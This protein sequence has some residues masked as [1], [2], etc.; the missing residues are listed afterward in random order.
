MKM[1]KKKV[2][3]IALA[4]ALIAILSFGTLAWFNST[5]TVTNIFNV[6]TSDEDPDEIFSVDIWEHVDKDGN[7]A[8][9]D[10]EKDQDGLTFDDIVPGG[11]YEKTPYVENTGKYDQWV[12][13]VVTVTDAEAWTNALGE[14]YELDKIFIGHPESNWERVFEPYKDGDTL[15]Y[16]YYYKNVLK[17]GDTAMLFKAVQLPGE[18]TQEDIAPLQGGFELTLRA[19]AIQA[20]AIGDYASGH[21]VPGVDTAQ[22]AFSYV[23]WNSYETYEQAMEEFNP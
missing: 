21:G 9:S 15:N 14:G 11:Y 4:I 22:E 20:D 5:D 18:L 10:D 19:D 16:V 2:F 3:V 13:I 23:G 7:D 8:V 17:P 6:A 1:N 12:R